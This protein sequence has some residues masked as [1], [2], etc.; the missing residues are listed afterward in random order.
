MNILIYDVNKMPLE[1]LKHVVD[2]IKQVS[3]S[4]DWIVLPKGI[5]VIQDAPVEYLVCIRDALD[6]R[7]REFE[8]K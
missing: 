7:I 8:E 1:Q 6:K 4:N 5:D 2:A 3:D